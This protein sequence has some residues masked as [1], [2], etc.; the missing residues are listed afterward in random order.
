MNQSV[1]AYWAKLFVAFRRQVK[2]GGALNCSFAGQ[3]PG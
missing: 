3:E 2:N 1:S